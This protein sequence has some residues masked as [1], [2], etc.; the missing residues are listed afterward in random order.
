MR[1]V[2]TFGFNILKKKCKGTRWVPVV[3]IYLIF[4][5]SFFISGSA[6]AQRPLD[7][8]DQLNGTYKNPV[9]NADYRL[10]N[11]ELGQIYVEQFEK[12]IADPLRQEVRD[13]RDE[14]KELRNELEMVKGCVCYRADCP[15]RVRVLDKQQ[16]GDE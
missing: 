11:M 7:W 4:H 13:L 6:F 15:H 10:K 1:N 5:F 14:V 9:L 2:I 16:S 8:G 12:N 3:I